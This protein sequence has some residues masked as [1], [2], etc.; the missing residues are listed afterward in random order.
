MLVPRRSQNCQ[1]SLRLW[2]M[3]NDRCD[4]RPAGRS[5]IHDC[6][7]SSPGNGTVEGLWNSFDE[8][9]E[10]VFAPGDTLALKSNVTCKGNLSPKGSGT[11]SQ[12]IRLTSYPIDSILG[13]PVIHAD[14]ANSS[15]LLT[16]QDHWRITKI[17]FT[18]PASNVARRQG[19][20]ILANDG[21]VHY[22]ITIEDNTIYDVAGQTNKTPLESRLK[23]MLFMDAC[24][25]DGIVVQYSDAPSLDHNV[26]SLEPFPFMGTFPPLKAGIWVM[27]SHNPVMRHNVVYG[28]IMSLHDSTAFDC[29]W[30]VTGTCI[31]EYNYS[32]DNAGGA[33]LD[34]DG[35]GVSGGARQIVRY[36]IFENDCRMISVSENSTLEFY[37]N[38]MYCA[39]RDFEL[40][41]PQNATKMTNNIFVGRENATL[42]VASNIVWENN[43]FHGLMPP[44]EDGHL[45]DPLFASP[46]T[47]GST[48]GAV[49]GYKLRA[50]S[51][52]IGSGIA[53]KDNGGKDY[54]GG[55]LGGATKPNIG[56]YSGKGI[57]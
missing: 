56:P 35:C 44:T 37:N 3:N 4:R 48:L 34:C 25:G 20:T 46:R 42:P 55:R 27:A 16:N 45:G 47:R 57:N 24:G 10:F 7:A 39:D 12:P 18:N 14:G 32:H 2:P 8:P 13:P 15:L 21:G 19:I 22:G 36:N 11:S 29:D 49:F 38:A 54:F 28:S 51:P 50:G 26:R 52:A 53:I 9:N 17:A 23:R 5:M 1:V 33:F 6:G 43:L 40:Q 31:V 30:G 41:L